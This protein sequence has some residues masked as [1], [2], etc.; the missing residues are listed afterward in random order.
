MRLE[1]GTTR[2]PIDVEGESFVFDF[3][4]DSATSGAGAVIHD[5]R[6]EPCARVPEA[7]RRLVA[8]A[9]RFE[10]ILTEDGRVTAYCTINGLFSIK[11]LPGTEGQRSSEG[12]GGPTSSE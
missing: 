10:E 2:I 1:D 6:V 9:K 12:S 8:P 4:L 11:V 5:F 7:S 3:A